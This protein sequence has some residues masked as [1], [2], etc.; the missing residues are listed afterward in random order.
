V[1]A[2]LEVRAMNARRTAHPAYA[3]E[4]RE[5]GDFDIDGARDRAAGRKRDLP[6]PP[7]AP[8]RRLLR[9]T[10]SGPGS[11]QAT[12]Q[13]FAL[14]QA[15][16]QRAAPVRGGPPRAGTLARAGVA[17]SPQG[18]PGA[19]EQRLAV[20]ASRSKAARRK[21]PRA[22]SSRN[23]GNPPSGLRMSGNP[24]RLVEIVA[25]QRFMT[26]SSREMGPEPQRWRRAARGFQN[27][28]E[29]KLPAPRRTRNPTRADGKRRRRRPETACTRNRGHSG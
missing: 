11:S 16:E 8:D 24:G 23:G 26:S 7:P 5:H 25:A 17:Q 27:S 3:A 18:L 28:E 1:A 19:I 20:R 10:A 15:H 12:K 4:R 22:D 21:Y 6:A 29:S 14:V 9:P 13:I 2:Q